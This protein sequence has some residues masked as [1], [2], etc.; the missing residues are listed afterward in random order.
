M[1]RKVLLLALIGITLAGAFGSTLAQKETRF[2]IDAGM[3]Y[4]MLSKLFEIEQ[5][6]AWNAQLGYRVSPAFTLGLV[7]E[8]M[9]T[10][11]DLPD[12]R[13]GPFPGDEG[14]ESR[15]DQEGDVFLSC[16]GDADLTL[17][18]VSGTFVVAGDPGFE[19]LTMVSFGQGKLDIS[20][21]E[22]PSLDLE[23]TDISL[24]YEVG[25]GA[26]W[27]RGDRWNFKFTIALRRIRP[28]DP[29]DVLSTARTAFVPAFQVGYRF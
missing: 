9:S 4:P 3:S 25:A 27:S 6:T 14:G 5:S 29:N 2:E 23:D 19:L 15:L 13:C 11:L 8:S 10:T 12:L 24:W 7:Y 26:Q 21:P 16:G 28:K 22:K 17:Y 18:G 1:K 20:A